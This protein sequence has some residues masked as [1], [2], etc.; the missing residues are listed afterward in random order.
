MPSN[1]LKT[2]GW[3][4]DGNSSDV[5]GMFFIRF[6]YFALKIQNIYLKTNNSHITTTPQPPNTTN[7]TICTVHLII[8]FLI[9]LQ[10]MR[11]QSMVCF[12]SPN[13]IMIFLRPWL[14][15]WI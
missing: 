4:A 14:L 3:S 10:Q 6:H 13:C 11:V 15:N 12:K 8:D 5:S 2:D 1:P 9:C 7:I